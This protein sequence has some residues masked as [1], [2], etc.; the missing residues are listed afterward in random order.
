MNEEGLGFG[1]ITPRPSRT[2]SAGRTRKD[3]I[4]ETLEQA[5][6]ELVEA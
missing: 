1:G 2:R 6:K 3:R 4:E 5:R